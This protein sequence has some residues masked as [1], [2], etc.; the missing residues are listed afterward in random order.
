MT[1]PRAFL[2]FGFLLLLLLAAMLLELS[3]Q[4]KTK[5]WVNEAERWTFIEELL[6]SII[7]DVRHR[8]YVSKSHTGVRYVTSLVRRHLMRIEELLLEEEMY[9]EVVSVASL[10]EELCQ[11]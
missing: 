2:S 5:K 1:L 10:E 4:N 3:T 8:C 6:D 11:K 7:L 9:D